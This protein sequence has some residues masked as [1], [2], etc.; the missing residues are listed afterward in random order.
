MAEDMERAEGLVREGIEAFNRRDF[1]AAVRSLHPDVVWHRVS[2][3]ERPLRG[4]AAVREFLDPEVFERQQ[5]EIIGIETVADCV[6]VE[7]DFHGAGRGSGIE[8]TQRG[9]QLWRVKDALVIEFRYFPERDQ[10][11]RAAKTGAV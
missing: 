5:L 1:D 7:G 9:W 10:A 6:L 8:L 2:D 11:V 3:F 4:R